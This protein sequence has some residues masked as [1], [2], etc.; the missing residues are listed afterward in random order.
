LKYSK[1][2]QQTNNKQ[3]KSMR[4]I[5]GILALTLVVAQAHA[6]S[7]TCVSKE[8]KITIKYD[9]SNGFI[10]GFPSFYKDENLNGFLSH[11]NSTEE[12]Y[13][14]GQEVSEFGKLHVI[15]ETKILTE[16]KN[17]NESTQEIKI[18]EITKTAMKQLGLRKN[19]SI[20]VHC[21]NK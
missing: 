3:E 14:I 19:R 17:T 20:T 7:Y 15:Y 11:E 6:G 16:N 2:E 8:N 18:T 13:E 21:F 4:S 12:K 5:F 9:E 10:Y 1:S